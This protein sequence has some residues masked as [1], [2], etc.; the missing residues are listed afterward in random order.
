MA[1]NITSTDKHNCTHFHL[2]T[3]LQVAC[4]IA[5][6]AYVIM[7]SVTCFIPPSPYTAPASM[8]SCFLSR[9]SYLLL[10]P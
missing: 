1:W 9:V 10:L 8:L 2:T 6:M 7:L 5:C 3:T 4:F